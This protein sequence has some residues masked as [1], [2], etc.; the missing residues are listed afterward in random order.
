MTAGP[1]FYNVDTASAM[2]QDLVGNVMYWPTL[3][4]IG[5]GMSVLAAT[6]LH[7]RFPLVRRRF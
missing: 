6:Y 5:V 4:L 2:I 1:R 7:R 3:G